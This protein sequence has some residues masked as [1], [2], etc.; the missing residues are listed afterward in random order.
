MPKTRAAKKTSAA[1]K[2]Q[3]AGKKTPAAKK[4]PAARN[5][6]KAVSASAVVVPEDLGAAEAVAAFL[7]EAQQIPASEILPMRSDPALAHH[8]VLVGLD[9]VKPR[10]AE[11]AGLPAPF[12]LGAMKSLRPLSLG[13]VHAAA[14]VDR[15]SSGKIR[16]QITRA[17]ELR[18]ILLTSAEALMKTGV[19]PGPKVKRIAAGRGLRDAVQDCVDLAQ[20]FREHAAAIAGKTAV[21]PEQIDE[22]AAVGNELLSVL[23]VKGAKTKLPEDLRTS[24]DTRDRLWTLLVRRHDDQLRRAGM[25]LWVDD[26]DEHVPPLL[27]RTVRRSKKPAGGDGSAPAQG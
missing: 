6:R 14:Q 22:A 9:A 19:L 4:A 27:A 24:I 12:D 23:K 7:V 25:W 2:T 15:S 21:T 5:A 11:L 3:T 18:D 17:S 13:V 26:V 10:E 1:K 16:K 8:N 20:L